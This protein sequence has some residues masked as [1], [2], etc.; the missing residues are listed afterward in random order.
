MIPLKAFMQT[1]EKHFCLWQTETDAAARSHS[2]S[3]CWHISTII[4]VTGKWPFSIVDHVHF[5]IWQG[6]NWWHSSMKLTPLAL[7]KHIQPW[8]RYLRRSMQTLTKTSYHNL[9]QTNSYNANSQHNNSTRKRNHIFLQS[10]LTKY[11]SHHILQTKH[12]YHKQDASN[13]IIIDNTP[14]PTSTFHS[15]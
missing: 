11:Q 14:N 15:S 10:K 9:T 1:T 4:V 12:H 3:F 13:K 7:L 2:T 5:I 6:T 8:A